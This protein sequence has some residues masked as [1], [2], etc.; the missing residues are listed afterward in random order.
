MDGHASY[1]ANKASVHD[2][3]S[4]RAAL[5]KGQW[6]FAAILSCADSRVTPELIFD[7]GPGDLFIVRVAGNVENPD[8]LASLEY[9]AK[10]LGIPLIM[11]LGHSSCGAVDAAV[12]VYRDK[13][14]LPGHLPGLADAIVPA[15][16]KAAAANP[17]DL[18]AA[19]ITENVR[20][21]MADIAN[22]QPI[23][24]PMV[25]HGDVKV[26]GAVFDVP[27]GKVALL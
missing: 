18:L 26:V 9:G 12:K 2:Y 5:S 17:S 7:Q 23:L 24:G 8:G 11:V 27:T 13:A 25:Q 22:N 4:R 19:S 20:Q 3:A 6:P 21:T 15:V 14:Q 16:Q 1:M 10:F